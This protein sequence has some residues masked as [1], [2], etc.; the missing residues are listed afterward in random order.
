MADIAAPNLYELACANDLVTYST[1]SIDGSPRFSFQDGDRSFSAS[2]PEI[3]ARPTDLGTE[4]TVTLESIPDDRT[5]TLT[6]LIPGVNLAEET[7]ASVDTVLIETTNRTSIGGP[8][9]VNGQ[10]QTY[11]TTRLHGTARIVDF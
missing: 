9:L 2:G 11:R 6:L 10:L 1:S 5:V 4:V 7:E 3:S 8:R